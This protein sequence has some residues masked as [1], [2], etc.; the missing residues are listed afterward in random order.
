MY[1]LRMIKN[2]NKIHLLLLAKLLSNQTAYNLQACYTGT[3]GNDL[4]N[5]MMNIWPLATFYVQLVAKSA[6]VHV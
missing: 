6:I 5:D 1:I 2:E 3:S 4:Q